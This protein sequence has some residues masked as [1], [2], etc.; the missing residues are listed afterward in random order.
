[1]VHHARIAFDDL[2]AL[3]GRKRPRNAKQHAAAVLDQSITRFGFITPVVLNEVDGT[4]LD[5]HGRLESLARRRAV[6][7]APPPGIARS[8][9]G[10]WLVPVVRDVHLPPQEAEAFTV[11]ANRVVELGGWDPAQLA[12]VLAEVAGTTDGLT[13]TGFA[14][15]DLETLVTELDQ[16]WAPPPPDTLPPLEETDAPR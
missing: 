2:D 15:A 10:A 11:A 16:T 5:G 3:L 8:A 14:L 13:G 6:G 4:L 12:S 1:M 7:D 9:D